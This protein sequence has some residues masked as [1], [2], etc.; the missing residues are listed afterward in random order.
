MSTDSSSAEAV[1]GR[2]FEASLA[3]MDLFMV[4]LGKRLGLYQALKD[5]GPASSRDLASRLGLDERYVREWLEQ[6]TAT[7]LLRAQREAG[8]FRFELPAGAAEV[9]LDVESL[10]HM[11][12]VAGMLVA[13]A[14]QLGPVAEAFKSG[15]GVEWSDYGPDMV[16]GQGAFNRPMYLGQLCQEYLPQIPGLVERL[17]RPGARI[18]DL[19]CGHGWSSVAM[20][21]AY[22]GVRVEGLDLDEPSLAAARGH[23]AEKGVGARTTFRSDVA[24]IQAASYDLVT[25]FECIHDMAD[26]VSVLSSMR[27]MVKPGGTVLVVDERVADEFLGEATDDVERMMYGWSVLTCLPAGR[28]ADVSAATGTVMRLPVLQEYA[29]SAGF[30]GVEVLPIENDF[31]RFYLLV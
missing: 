14:N 6:Q 21:M 7:G 3:T 30:A 20:A 15:G 9:L 17:N 23:A 22:P 1:A 8:C 5:G 26:P 4:H 24:N 16:N 25:A 27:A 31:F 10:N 13:A 29:R 2:L 11:G 19:G 18:A 12:P 28:T